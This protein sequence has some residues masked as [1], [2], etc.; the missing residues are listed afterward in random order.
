M[1]YPNELIFVGQA[2]VIGVS[3]LCA[4]TLGK[5]ALVAF[6]CLQCVLAN[7]FVLKQITL[8]GLQATA[9]DAFTIG[10]T[11]GLNLL[12][13]Y[14]GRG[15]TRNT[16]WINFFLLIFYTIITQLQLAYVPNIHDFAHPHLYGLLSFVPRI[17]V[18]SFS[19]YLFVQMLDY[20]LYG[21]LKKMFNQKYLVLRNYASIAAC[22]LVDTVLFSFLGLYGIIDNLF[23][24]MIVSY[25]I[26][27]I[28]IGMTTPFVALSRSI[29]KHKNS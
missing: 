20:H 17:V 13:E 28:V 6:V 26:K 8:F 15:I 21:L 24:V 2:I 19:V 14:Y 12:Q 27:L 22:Q 3:A 9:S 10:A 23:H 5:E 1:L 25:L 7:L 16:I 29:Y 18:A 11:L 4:L